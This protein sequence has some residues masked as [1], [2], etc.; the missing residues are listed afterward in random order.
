MA[1][2]LENLCQELVEISK[3][4]VDKKELTLKDLQNALKTAQTVRANRGVLALKDYGTILFEE[5]MSPEAL[6]KLQKS[7]DYKKI[8]FKI[9]NLLVITK[10]L[11][12]F[13][14][15]LLLRYL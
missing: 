9:L 1:N 2:E 4:Y 12:K 7:P 8:C 10:I 14:A 15:K 3:D 11:S 13:E 5:Y 6:Q